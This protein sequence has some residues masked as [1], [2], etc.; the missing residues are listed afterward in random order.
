MA[1]AWFVRLFNTTISTR[2]VLTLD[3]NWRLGRMLVKARQISRRRYDKFLK[4]CQL[5][6]VTR[7]SKSESVEVTNRCFEYW[8]IP[9]LE[10][11][12]GSAVAWKVCKIR[13]AIVNQSWAW[14][15]RNNCR[16]VFCPFQRRAVTLVNGD[17]LTQIALNTKFVYGTGDP[18]H[19]KLAALFGSPTPL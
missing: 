16:D 8:L 17:P 12:G 3:A 10:S 18:A 14:N 11:P 15:K 7:M 13:L 5:R 2:H 6:L 4:I 1:F 19:A 9:K